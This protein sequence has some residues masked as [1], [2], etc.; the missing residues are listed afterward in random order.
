[1]HGQDS[2]V[3]RARKRRRAR[4]IRVGYDY[5]HSAVDDHT[6]LAYSEVLPDE[7][8]ASAIAFWT[9][10]RVLRLYGITVDHR[11]TCLTDNGS[12]FCASVLG[13]YL[14]ARASLIATPRH[15]DR[16]PRTWRCCAPHAE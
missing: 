3:N 2:E 1:M 8:A 5:V 16:R 14:A 9:G 7:T 15:T 6:R 4:R 11:W 12:Y 13:A 10:H